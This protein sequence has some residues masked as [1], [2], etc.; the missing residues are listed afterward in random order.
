V[1]VGA[2]LNL[3]VGG[4]DDL[5]DEDNL[6]IRASRKPWGQISPG[7]SQSPSYAR[8]CSVVAGV[9]S[10]LLANLYMR[11]FVLGWKKLGLEWSLGSRIVTYA[12]D[13]VILCKKGKADEALLKLRELMG[14][15]KL[16]VNEDKTRVCKVPEGE[17][18]FLGYTFGRMYSPRTGQARL[19]Y[20]PS[21]KSISHMVE[22]IHELT[23]EKTGWQDATVLVGK[24]NRSL[25]GWANYFQVGTV[26]KAYR[27]IDSYTAARLSRWLRNKHKVRR[28][29][30]GDYPPSYLYEAMGLVRL[31]RLGHDVSWVKA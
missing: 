12:D 31:T 20:R 5:N 17:F 8:V 2:S 26:S 15:L 6:D 19:G 16:T 29:G 3:P 11:R 30:F 27:A 21:K 9:I 28:R 18:D 10:P 23:A 13:L 22:T 24:L 1:I 4:I 25:R 14:K 7:N